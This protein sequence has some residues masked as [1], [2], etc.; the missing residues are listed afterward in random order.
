MTT[1]RMK[2][3]RCWRDACQKELAAIRWQQESKTYWLSKLEKVNKE[4]RALEQAA[5]NKKEA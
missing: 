1:A 2:N 4:I 3:L 5:E